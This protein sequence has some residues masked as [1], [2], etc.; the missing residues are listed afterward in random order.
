MQP[1][2]TCTNM[3]PRNHIIVMCNK[4]GNE[5][6]SLT[7]QGEDTKDWLVEER[8][9]LGTHHSCYSFH[10]NAGTVLWNGPWFLPP[11]SFPFSSY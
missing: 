11:T 4:F 3:I 6:Y 10:A 5:L 8:V 1:E 2:S 7:T 9:Q